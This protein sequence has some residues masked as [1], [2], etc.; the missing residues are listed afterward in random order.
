MVGMI[1]VVKLAMM[2]VL[3]PSVG[4]DMFPRAA[5]PETAAVGI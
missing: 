1:V 2:A 4:V 5:I 3:V